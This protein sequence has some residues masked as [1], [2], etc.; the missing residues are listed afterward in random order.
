MLKRKLETATRESLTHYPAVGLLGP[1][2]VGK[3]TLALTLS[4]VMPSI[5][6]DLESDRDRAK[7]S[8]PESYL[9]S[10]ADKLVILDEIQRLAGLFQ[11][12]RGLIDRARR[13]GKATGRYLIL[14]SAS[15]DLLRQ[16]S[17]SLA[18]RITYLE[19]APLLLNEVGSE[20]RDVLW[21]RGGFPD[22]YLAADDAWSLRWR[23]DF[24][25]TYLERDVPQLGPRIPAE[26]LR[27][28]WTMLAHQQ[29][30]LLN[31]AALARSL[32]VDG[33]TVAKYIDLM[34]DLLLVR[35][36][37]PWYQDVGK[38]L[39]KSPK[40]YVRD[41]GLTHALLGL[42]DYDTLLSHPAVGGSWEG[43][44]VENVLNTVPPGTAAYFYRTSAGAE[45]DL[46]LD[47][48]GQERWVIEIKR[49][50]A[51]RIDKGFYHAY[52]D[53]KPDAAFVV[54]PGDECYPIKNNIEAVNLGSLMSRFT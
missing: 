18:G 35:R 13:S 44:V 27:R 22:S 46:V 25:R 38:R 52:E 32:G 42:E 29:A 11:H 15:L 8:D 54:Y 2:Q 23:Q 40:L 7:L 1:R 10:Q 41:S 20:Q 48:P 36:L 45:V 6:L 39:V 14:G 4:R 37:R 33:K 47:L 30:S 34:V 43:F 26:T 24:I 5:Y 53:L 21:L 28:F 17:E 3:T 50:T 51:P 12:L 49:S 9:E 16:S 19:L 31:A